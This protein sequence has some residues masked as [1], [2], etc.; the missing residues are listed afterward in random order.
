MFSSSAK[1]PFSIIRSASSIHKN[2]IARTLADNSSSC[3]SVMVQFVRV[4]STYRLHQIPKTTRGSNKD[5]TS[6]LHN[7]LLFLRAQTTNNTSNTDSWWS[8]GRFDSL[9]DDLVQVIN[10]LDSQLSSGT[11]DQS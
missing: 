4:Y 9:S 8:L 2:R 11:E 10:D 1:W 5:I 6:S 3:S 7:P